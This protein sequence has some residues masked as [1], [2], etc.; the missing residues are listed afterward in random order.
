M[1]AKGREQLKLKAGYIRDEDL[2]ARELIDM[3]SIIDGAGVDGAFAFTFVQ[4]ALPYSGSPKHDLDLASYAIVTS[5]ADR[6]G[7]A[8]PD[9][10][11]NRNRHSTALP[12]TTRRHKHQV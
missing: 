6:Q 5:F 10:R 12:S 9:C 7:T 3:I 4:P 1:I 11:G 2:Q 8:Y